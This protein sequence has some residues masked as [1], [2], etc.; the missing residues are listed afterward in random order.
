M[1]YL[2]LLSFF[3]LMSCQP[4]KITPI[5][6]VSFKSIYEEEM[7]IR[8]ITLSK[9]SLYFADHKGRIGAISIKDQ[10]MRI[11]TVNH[12][13]KV[14]AFRSIGVNSKG[15]FFLNVE[16]PALLYRRDFNG[17]ITLVYQEQAEGVFY[18]AL[19][20]MNDRIGYALGDNFDGCMSVLKTNDGGLHWE[21]LSCELLPESE[22]GEG[23]FAA[24]NTNI[25]SINNDMWMVTT[26]GT[27][28][29]SSKNG[30]WESYQTP[31]VDSLAT[32]GIYSMDF[33]NENL[34]VVY[35]GD[36]TQP[37]Y[38]KNNFAITTDGG[39]SWKLTADGSNL[40]YKS[41][42]QY[43]PGSNGNQIVVV[44]Y[45][46]IGVSNDGGNTWAS[47]SKEGFYTLRFINESTAYA[48]GKGR[49]AK[50]EF[51]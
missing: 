40:G 16:N 3:V 30:N 38:N 28:Y 34:G 8:A 31:V 4:K 6:S 32:H 50:L 42:V 23:A 43:V 51:N 10:G 45:T 5:T 39:I 49:I 35:G 9:D 7:S 48:A 14:P 15:V 29:K 46:G 36:Y 41:C 27:L 13:G 24:S 17:K 21:K 11:D 37:T 18:D 25:E 44:G 19:H 1:K 22:I 12:Q 26:E 33:Y 47:L 2:A 20:F